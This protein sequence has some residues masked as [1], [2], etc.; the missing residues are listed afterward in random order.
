M[1]R[2]WGELRSSNTRYI[3]TCR[4]RGGGEGEE[5]KGRRGRGGG[6]EEEGKRRRGRGG[7]E[8]EEGK[9]RRGRGGG[10]GRK[11]RGGG[12]GEEGKGRRGRGG[13]EGEEIGEGEE[14]EEGGEEREW[15]RREGRLLPFRRCHFCVH[16]LHKVVSW[17]GQL[18]FMI[19]RN[20]KTICN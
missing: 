19:Y 15:R 2:H 13:G 14:R 10:E 1:T 3:G 12:E 17:K 8:G 9:G 7:W 20:D 18:N 6:E 5:G 11:E 4:G 16:C